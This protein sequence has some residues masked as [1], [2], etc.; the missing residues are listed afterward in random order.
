MVDVRRFKRAD[1]PI[2][3]PVSGNLTSADGN[4][5]H[6]VLGGASLLSLED[7]VEDLASAFRQQEHAPPLSETG[8]GR[9]PCRPSLYW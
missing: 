9:R 4:V 8:G 7:L 1:E 5:L 2:E 3:T 6:V